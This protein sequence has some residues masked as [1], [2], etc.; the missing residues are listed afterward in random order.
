MLLRRFNELSIEEKQQLGLIQKNDNNQWNDWSLGKEEALLQQA[1][2]NTR[3]YDKWRYHESSTDIYRSS[4]GVNYIQKLYSGIPYDI[5]QIDD[6]I[7]ISVKECLKDILTLFDNKDK[8]K[9]L[10]SIL[11][12]K[13]K[14]QIDNI[15]IQSGAETLSR[16]SEK[17]SKTYINRYLT[18]GYIKRVTQSVVE[19]VLLN[20]QIPIYIHS[21]TIDK[22]DTIPLSDFSKDLSRNILLKDT[23]KATVTFHIRPKEETSEKSIIKYSVSSIGTGGT[24]S[25]VIKIINSTILSGVSCL[26]D[27]FPIAHDIFINQEIIQYNIS[28]PVWTHCLVQLCENNIINKTM[29]ASRS[30]I[31]PYEQLSDSN[32]IG[33]GDFCDF[34]ILKSAAKAALNARLRAIRYTNIDLTQYMKEICQKIEISKIRYKAQNY[35]TSYPFSSFAKISC[36]EEDI[37]QPHKNKIRILNKYQ[38][39]D[40]NLEI[41]ETYLGEGCYKKA[42]EYLI[43]LSKLYNMDELSEQVIEWYLQY[44]ENSEIPN[45][46]S[47]QNNTNNF[48]HI[49][50]SSHLIRYEICRAMYHYFMELD[51]DI[52]NIHR[53]EQVLA[54]GE[55][56][57]R[58]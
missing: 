35:V 37:L 21:I 57:D 18:P 40:T 12:K 30:E 2:I 32:Y 3:L 16:L 25:Q 52:N 56:N 46:I 43:K 20:E 24:L 48:L 29:Y 10:E 55:D 45:D 53:K 4:I 7:A 11:F 58:S 51:D 50:S 5:S 26:K 9:K 34:D 28:S 38:L 42:Y 33:R 6:W 44:K 39:I 13:A 23:Y 17:S 36:L 27:F 22:I 8:R 47:Y 14:N 54:R 15:L 31:L 1:L 19:N 49:A 41:A